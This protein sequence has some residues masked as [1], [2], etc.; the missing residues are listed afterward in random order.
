[1]KRLPILLALLAAGCEDR[2]KGFSELTL[3]AGQNLFYVGD[4]FPLTI[5]TTYDETPAYL[6]L[7]IPVPEPLREVLASDVTGDDTV[8]VTME[9]FRLE[10]SVEDLQSDRSQQ[11]VMFTCD[12]VGEA[13]I[14][15][16]LTARDTD[17]TV[18]FERRDEI[19]VECE[20]PETSDDSDTTP[21]PEDDDDSSSESGDPPPPTTCDEGQQ[22]AVVTEDEYD[23]SVNGFMLTVNAAGIVEGPPCEWQ[24]VP[25][26]GG[27]VPTGPGPSRMDADLDNGRIYHGNLGDNTMTILELDPAT[28]LPIEVE[29]SPFVLD[30]T[31]DR[32]LYNK[33]GFLHLLDSM[34]MVHTFALADGVPEM[35][36]AT[37]PLPDYALG[38]AANSDGTRVFATTGFLL[39]AFDV[40]G[41]GSTSMAPDSPIPLSSEGFYPLV[42]PDDTHVFVSVDAG[43]DVFR[44]DDFS[45]VGDGPVRI[46]GRGARLA[47]TPNA[48]IL[49]AAQ[50]YMGDAIEG[51]RNEDGVLTPLA[52]SPFVIG[53][54]PVAIAVDP[55]GTLLLAGHAP[56]EPPGFITL[57]GID[58]ETG[59][60]PIQQTLDAGNANVTAAM[61]PL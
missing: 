36:V 41:D 59:A 42:S 15:V 34:N 29:G 11:V 45:R 28:S 20:P 55:T 6:E 12:D 25:I 18:K 17:G 52:D 50:A 57:M 24:A 26:D 44:T 16:S 27:P 38:M 60:I 33:Q 56:L 21:P 19:W 13:T 37:M 53:E 35:E 3:D 1:M 48:R 9:G 43:I 4:R 22:I 47:M 32:L 7:E 40:A 54:R 31:L 58:P 51:F 46:L 2:G 10:Y 8:I 23:D 39:S 30:F 5:T 49:F 61:F 14:P